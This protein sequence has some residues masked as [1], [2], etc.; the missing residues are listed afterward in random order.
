MSFLEYTN[1]EK[2]WK[3]QQKRLSRKEM[4]EELARDFVGG[5]VLFAGL[6]AYVITMFCF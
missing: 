1:I 4:M 3:I 2:K 5:L 6:L